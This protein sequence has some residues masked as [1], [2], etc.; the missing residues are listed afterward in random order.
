MAYTPTEIQTTVEKLVLSSI[1]RPYD[2][3]GVRRVDVSFSDIQEAAAG[4]FQLYNRAAFYVCGLAAQRVGETLAAEE[5][6]ITQVI[7]GAEATG[8]R[9]LPV[10]DISSLANAR[11]ALLDLEGAVAG[12]SSGFKSI[13]TVP[14]FQRFKT[15][16]DRFLATAGAA[17]KENGQIVSTPQEAKMVLPGLVTQLKAAHQA[18]VASVVLLAGA[19]D[20]YAQVNIPTLVASGVISKAR[21][22]LD[23]KYNELAAMS[24]TER[25][26][27]IKSTVL[28][29]LGTKAVVK[30]FGSFT[31]SSSVLA[32]TGTGNPYSDAKHLATPAFID[33]ERPGPYAIT[34]AA[35]QLSVWLDGHVPPAPADLLVNL[36]LSPLAEIPGQ[37]SEPYS[38]VTASSDRLRIQVVDAFG[39]HIYAGPLTAWPTRT[40]V[41]A[42]ADINAFLTGSNH[43]AEPYFAPLKFTG[44][45]TVHTAISGDVIFTSLGSNFVSLGLTVGD[46]VR[47]GLFDYV[48]T[49]V[50]TTTLTTTGPGVAPD[51]VHI[52]AGGPIRKIRIRTLS[53]IDSINN[54]E[55]ITVIALTTQ[56]RG[57]AN[58]L[59]L[60][61]DATFE[62]LRVDA[63][64]VAKFISSAS[65]KLS[66]AAA[67]VTSAVS[68]TARS[69]PLDVM[70]LTF[71][72]G[73]GTGD[74][75]T[76]SAFHLTLSNISGDTSAIRPGHLLVLRTGPN[77]SSIWTIATVS[78]TT[79]TATGTT[80]PTPTTS[81]S[82]ESGP[83]VA[84]TFGDR[85]T[86]EDGGNKGDYYIESD[87]PG[88]D[89]SL[90]SSLP[91]ASTLSGGPIL[92]TVTI[93]REYLHIASADV[94]IASEVH[95]EVDPTSSLFF[96]SLP[97]SATGMTK[98][99]QL[100]EVPGDLVTGDL[101][102]LYESD[103][104]AS[105]SYSITSVEKDDRIIGLSGEIDSRVPW[106]MTEGNPPPFAK[107]RASK[108][109]DYALF[110]GRLRT[111]AAR[112]QQQGAYFTDLNR[113]INPLLANNNPTDTQIGDARNKSNELLTYL[114]LNGA[115]ANGGNADDTIEGILSSYSVDP[116]PQVDA[117][118]KTFK[119]KSADRAIDLLLSGQFSTFFGLTI[120]QTSYAGA[121]QDNMKGVMR[122][123]LPVRKNNRLDNSVS[124]K[125]GT[126]DSV[127]YEYSREGEDKTGNIDPAG[128]VDPT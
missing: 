10:K 18:L 125:V 22:V 25:L 110:S 91:I 54:Q 33:A 120:D 59:G 47:L 106:L 5:Q 52:D 79:I 67:L 32:V 69:N 57:A 111:W 76:P 46:L 115:A 64:V 100:P 98:W 103:Y 62:S 8:R 30:K 77:T 51:T 19:M 107:L 109:V 119:E 89:V 39:T 99:F 118:I 105:A 17:I 117:L 14:A 45:V 63:S 84:Y 38:I 113:F 124:R 9:V 71:Y 73:L 114:T 20:D 56:E 70:K 66:A 4:V 44:S 60:P 116:V 41:Q 27:V 121:M 75:T 65:P 78:D 82:W 31:A 16:I 43:I 49:A 6:I 68:I 24:E 87:S 11:S 42:C 50:S 34:E 1:R 93:G 55:K 40:A 123:D 15:N 2:T 61:I 101:L 86:I 35:S 53:D 13:E 26:T 7:Q 128:S 127:D 28:D 81:V 126:A 85:V 37:T 36:P 29:L 88:L 80:T 95:L 102:E 72:N 74:V 97:A 3:L 21:A 83:N 92:F 112:D 94:T 48:I 23:S 96:F 104:T 122:L 108:V 58:V 12:R 90:R